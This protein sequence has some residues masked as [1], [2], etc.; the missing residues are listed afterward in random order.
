MGGAE[1]ASVFSWQQDGAIRYVERDGVER[2]IREGDFL[3]GN[4]RA[5]A[6]SADQVVLPKHN[7]G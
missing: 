6:V 5:V 1:A 3:L 7:A 4:F 2:E